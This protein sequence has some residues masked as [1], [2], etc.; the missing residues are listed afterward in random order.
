[1]RQSEK[2]VIGVAW[3][4][5]EQWPL[6]LSFAADANQLEPTHAQWLAFATKSIEEMRRQGIS[7]QKVEID[8]RELLAW[9]QRHGRLLDGDARAAFAT[10]KM[11]AEPDKP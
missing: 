5:P 1:M 3:Y 7:V 8:V 2:V 6:L 11:Q 10:S 9:C 4:R